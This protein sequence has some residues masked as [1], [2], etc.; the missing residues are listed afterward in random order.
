MNQRMMGIK[1]APD[2]SLGV[3]VFVAVIGSVWSALSS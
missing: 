3:E 2:V 1:S